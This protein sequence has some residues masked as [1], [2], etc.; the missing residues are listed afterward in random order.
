MSAEQDEGP[1]VEEW[2]D[3]RGLLKAAVLSGEIP[4]EPKAMRPK[5]VYQKY[6]NNPAMECIKDYKPK[7]AVEKFR[8]MLE[9]LRKKH[10]NG[11]LL[12]EDK[13]K[14]IEWGK[15]AAKQFLKRCFRENLI[16]TDYASP[17]DVWDEHCQGHAAFARMSYDTTF[18]GRLRT[19]KNDHVKKAARCEKDLKAFTIA[20]KNHPTPEF[21]V[22]GEPQWNGSEAQRLLKEAI[23]LGQ[24]I[25]VEPELFQTDYAEWNFYSLQTFRDHIYQELGLLKFRNYVQGLKQ[26]KIDALQY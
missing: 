10:G 15:S 24:H 22:R 9:S 25:G 12:E 6:E 7:K 19:V 4:L 20:K 21:N 3:L 13:P 5:A 17:R 26:D 1:T 23:Q 11:D 2:K 14:A 8:R 16:A 18:T